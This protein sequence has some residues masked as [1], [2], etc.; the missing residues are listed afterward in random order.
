MTLNSKT[1]THTGRPRS[2][3]HNPCN[4]IDCATMNGLP[5]TVCAELLPAITQQAF[6]ADDSLAFG[7]PEEGIVR[8]IAVGTVRIEWTL[9]DGRR[10]VLG[11]LH[12]GDMLAKP[13][14][15]PEVHATA[16]TSGILY[17][18]D[19]QTYDRCLKRSGEAEKWKQEIANEL[20]IHLAAHATLLSRLTA[21]EKVATFLLDLAQRI[22]EQTDEGI[23]LFLSMGRED[24][25]D[26][27]G[28]KPETVSR[29]LSNLKMGGYL[30]LPKPGHAVI[31]D[32]HGLSSLSPLYFDTANIRHTDAA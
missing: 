19:A 28:L 14:N 18:I 2:N 22:G 12:R 17:L 30:E 29:A 25:A 20:V 6:E 32:W 9:R 8:L 13:E 1:F 10:H 16:V 3:F 27:L 26:H 23:S 4:A 7:K 11:F 21:R 5:P 31:R 24:I 15:L